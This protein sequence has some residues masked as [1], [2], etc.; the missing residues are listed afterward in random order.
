MIDE[1]EPHFALITQILN[2]MID[3]GGYIHCRTKDS[4]WSRFIDKL[5]TKVFDLDDNDVIGILNAYGI[6][7]AY[8]VWWK[9]FPGERPTHESAV[10]VT[11]IR[12]LAQKIHIYRIWKNAFE[13]SE[14]ESRVE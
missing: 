13:P 9:A 14:G 11:A 2:E 3:N 5:I 8:R 1:N 4:F 10:L 12:V 7:K 6:N